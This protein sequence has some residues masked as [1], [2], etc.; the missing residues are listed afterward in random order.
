[1]ATPRIKE[2]GVLLLFDKMN[3]LIGLSWKDSTNGGD[4][5]IYRVDK[6]SYGDMAEFLETLIDVNPNG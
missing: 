6:V 3:N 1:M 2:E 5:K 4:V